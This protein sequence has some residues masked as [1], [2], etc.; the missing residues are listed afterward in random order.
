MPALRILFFK[1]LYFCFSR[2][3]RERSKM[4]TLSGQ[5]LSHTQSSWLTNANSASWNV[6]YSYWLHM[7][8]RTT[9]SNLL[10]LP[11]KVQLPMRLGTDFGCILSFSFFFFFSLTPSGLTQVAMRY[12][13]FPSTAFSTLVSFTLFLSA[14]M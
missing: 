11:T 9:I 12:T 3:L 13:L 6:S 8:M 2:F 1:V 7:K 10:S 4:L 14:Y 5:L